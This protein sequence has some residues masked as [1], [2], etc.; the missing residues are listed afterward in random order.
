MR[1]AIKEWEGTNKNK[2]LLMQST[3]SCILSIWTLKYE[4]NVIA[5]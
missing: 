5:K 4:T 2:N 1:I 3:D